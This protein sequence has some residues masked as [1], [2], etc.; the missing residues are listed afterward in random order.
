MATNIVGGVELIEIAPAVTT[1]AGIT[2]ATFQRLENIA[3]DSVVYTKNSDTETDLIPEDKDVA[4]LTFYTPGEAD[5]IA[6]GVLEQ[7]P[8]ILALLFNQEYTEATT[9][10][11]TLAKRKVANLMIRIT[12]RSMKDGR[13]QVI[14]LPNV[15]VTTTF[16]N[17]LSKTAVQ[18]LLLT[19]KVGSFKTTTSLEDAISVKTWVTEAGAPI[20]SSTP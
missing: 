17:N 18:Q 1:E 12:T 14:V 3:P 15:A 8:E 20:D 9:R 10:I 5:T 4:L 2:G 11:V 6:I 19:G 16:V 13:K 7:K